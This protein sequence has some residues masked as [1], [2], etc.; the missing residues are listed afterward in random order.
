MSDTPETPRQRLLSLRGLLPF[1]RPHRGLLAGWLLALAFSSGATLFFPYAFRQVI[2][3]GFARG[4][5]E[6]NRWFLM[7]FAVAVVLACAT[8]VRF[9]TVS[10]LGERVIADLR[11]SLYAH[12]LALD[13]AFFERTRAGELLSRLSADAEMLRSIVGSSMSIALRSIITVADLRWS[14]S[15]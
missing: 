12:L 3:H 2:D 13:Q 1:V 9:Y 4:G 6:V 10:L 15:R 11:R 5:A 14:A 7:M 8:A